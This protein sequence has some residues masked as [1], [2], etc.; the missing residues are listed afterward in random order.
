MKVEIL[1]PA[2]DDLVDGHR[3]Y[4]MQDPG[5]GDYFLDTL[6]AEIDSL[7]LYAGTHPKNGTNTE[8]SQD[9]FHLEFST[10]SKGIRFMSPP[11]ST[12]EDARLSY[13]I[14]LKEKIRRTAIC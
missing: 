13:D 6:F 12:C 3:F 2:E 8:C 14:S 5:I 11:Y 7:Q 4:E 10:P 9:D 1:G